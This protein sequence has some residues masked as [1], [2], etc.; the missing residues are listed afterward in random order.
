M[1][2]GGELFDFIVKHGAFAEADC[3]YYFKQMLNGLF[4]MHQKGFAHRDL[5]PENLLINKNYGIKIVD[6]GFASRLENQ[7]GAIYTNDFIGTQGYMAPEIFL[8]RPY[9]PAPADIFALGIIL[10]ILRTGHP[11]F[12]SARL[13]D[14]HY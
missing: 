7:Y 4:Y 1:V 9:L 13:N 5:K 11:P 2:D 14:P 6:F 10:F 3:R 8:W 12:N